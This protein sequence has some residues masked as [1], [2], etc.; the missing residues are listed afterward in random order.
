MKCAAM[1]GTYGVTWRQPAAF[2][3]ATVGYLSAVSRASASSASS[4]SHSRLV[5]HGVPR[6]RAE[7]AAH[8]MVSSGASGVAASW[9]WSV[10]PDAPSQRSQLS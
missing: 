6:L 5:G 2:A 7:V 10:L 9:E 4:V 1:P 8:A 3:S